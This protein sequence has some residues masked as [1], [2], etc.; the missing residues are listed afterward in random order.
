MKKL[1]FILVLL[2]AVSPV[3]AQQNY[4]SID[5][6]SVYYYNVPVERVYP[7]VQGYIVQYRKSG[8]LD[9]QL[10][11][12]GLP[13]DWFRGAASKAEL[14]ILPPGAN[15]PSMSI[16]YRDGEFSHVRLYVHR[17][18]SHSTWGNIPLGT[19]LSRFFPSQDTLV[20]EY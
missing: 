12:I 13:L 16:F 14:I 4:S 3:F 20:I 17:V 5:S 9:Q 18:K 2:A 11:V 19:D 6:P 7:S 15:W 10:G 1:I 8:D